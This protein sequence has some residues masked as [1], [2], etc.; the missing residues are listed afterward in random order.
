[1][2]SNNNVSSNCDSVP[3]SSNCDI[4]SNTNVSSTNCYVLMPFINSKLGS[5]VKTFFHN[6]NVKVSFRTGRNLYTLLR[7]R[8]SNI[9]GKYLKANVIYKYKCNSC[10]RDYIGYTT[11]PLNVRVGEH[12]VKSSVLSKAHSSFDCSDLIDKKCFSVI[13]QGSNVFDLKVKEGYFINKYK[14]SFNTK[15]ESIKQNSAS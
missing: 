7:P 6:H 5:E 13:C 10:E 1:M 12:V 4:I 14:P 11:R 15:Y 2:S 9:K 8:E 3:E